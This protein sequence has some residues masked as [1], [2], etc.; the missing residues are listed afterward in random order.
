[1][2]PHYIFGYFLA[3][4]VGI[5]LGLI[6]SGGSILSLPILVYVMRVEPVLATAYSLF[7]VG[8]T[9]LIGGIK[10]VKEQLVDFKKAILFG[11]PTVIVV[12][13]MRIV[14]MPS[15]P[16]T[17]GV[18]TVLYVPKSVIIMIFFAIVMLFASISMI[19][20]SKEVEDISNSDVNYPRLIIQGILIGFIAGFVGAGGGFLIVPALL[21]FAKTPIKM[22]IGTSFF[23]IATQ[24]LLGFLADLQIQRN[25]NWQVLLFFTSCSVIGF[26][27]GNA[28]A[29]KISGERLKILFGYFVLAMGLFVLVKE[30]LNFVS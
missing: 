10:K 29:K 8:I 13:L 18:S 3:L 9:A 12:F 23:I 16:N 5:S 22:A 1:M 4:L 24:S 19:K 20:K 11:I 15:I 27:I 7:I 6:G 26:F 14:V 21:Y 2:E 17:I 25:I 28:M 30:L